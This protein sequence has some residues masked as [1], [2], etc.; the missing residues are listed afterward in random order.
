[1]PGSRKMCCVDF[2]AKELKCT[3][4]QIRGVGTLDDIRDANEVQSTFA[5]DYDS[6]LQ[7]AYEA[8]D[9]DSI[10]DKEREKRLRVIGESMDVKF[11]F[12][13]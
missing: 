10:T 8:D 4:N 9:S 5:G 13:P 1:M 7:E 2:L 6:S 12:V 3:T 11:V